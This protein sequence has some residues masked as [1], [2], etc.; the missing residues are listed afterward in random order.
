VVLYEVNWPAS[1]ANEYED[2]FI[3]AMMGRSAKVAENERAR[4]KWEL[5][6]LLSRD[7]ELNWLLK[8]FTRTI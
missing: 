7:K 3:S 1:F 4:K 6:E 5:D 8:D 2:D